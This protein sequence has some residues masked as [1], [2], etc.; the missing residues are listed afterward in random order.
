MYSWAIACGVF[1]YYLFL[2]GNIGQLTAAPIIFGTIVFVFYSILLAWK[3]APRQITWPQDRIAQISLTILFLLACINLIGALGPELGFDAIWYHLTIPRIWLMENQVMAI[4]HG[5]FYYALLPK[6]VDM[7]YLIPVLLHMEVGAKL[8]QFLFGLLSSYCTYKIGRQFLN[9]EQSLLAAVL[10]YGNLVVG[11]QSITAYIDLGRTF[12]ESL[13][14]LALVEFST[15]KNKKS[16][17]GLAV[18]LGLAVTSKILAFASSLVCTAILFFKKKYSAT[19]LVLIMSILIPLPWLIVNWMQ[20]GNPIHP[21]FSGYGLTSEWHTLD[22]FT[23]WIWSADPISP[24]YLIVLPLILLS[25]FNVSSQ[26]FQKLSADKVGAFNAL[27]W[28]SLGTLF[29]WWLLPRTGGGRFLMPY[30][31]AYSVLVAITI[32]RLKDKYIKRIII[33]TVLFLSVVSVL[34]RAGANARYLPYILGRESKNSF[35]QRNIDLN[36]GDNWYYLTDDS[37]QSIYKPLLYQEKAKPLQWQF[38]EE[39]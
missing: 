25:I 15:P 37:L 7:F 20:T 13:A 26:Y 36:F 31:P 30:L 8:L 17:L 6:L 23:V 28:Y 35:L 14:V 5:P 11:W 9:K 4:Q 24:I 22:I 16:A 34:Y 18:L 10:F 2:L 33:C 27:A 3:K 21:I 12:F 29:L 38:Q 39:N 32:S 19:F 1:S